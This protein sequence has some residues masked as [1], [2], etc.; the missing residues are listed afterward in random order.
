MADLIL[1]LNT[2]MARHDWNYQ[3]SDDYIVWS[4]GQASWDTVNRI[5]QQ[6]V[7]EG[8]R[9]E[10]EAAMTEFRAKRNIR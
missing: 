4:R 1:D 2:A 8:R 10:A 3:Y 9:S 6:L 5:F 7:R